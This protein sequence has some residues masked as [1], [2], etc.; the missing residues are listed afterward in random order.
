MEVSEFVKQP[1]DDWENFPDVT[2]QGLVVFLRKSDGLQ[3]LTSIKQGGGKDFICVSIG[4]ISCYNPSF[5]D[6]EWLDYI[7]RHAEEV[8]KE[9]FGG[10]KFVLEDTE[11]H[12][13][14]LH[15]VHALEDYKWN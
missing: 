1:N 9:F 8:L 11:S 3:L 2:G 15:F 6:K 13:V 4:K 14:M 5:S 7:S 10:R 12:W